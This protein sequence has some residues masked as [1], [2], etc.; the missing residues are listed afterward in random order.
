MEPHEPK[1]GVLMDTWKKKYSE[2]GKKI[3]RAYM[4][5]P[6][7]LSWLDVSNDNNRYQREKRDF[8]YMYIPCCCQTNDMEDPMLF[9][10]SQDI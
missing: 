2:N 4:Q 3:S 10:C 5:T 9:N 6:I 7:F 8:K 1:F